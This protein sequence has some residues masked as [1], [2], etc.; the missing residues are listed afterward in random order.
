MRVIGEGRW[1]E[2]WVRWRSEG[3]GWGGWKGGK[4]E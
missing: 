4:N 1:E 3:E 2:M